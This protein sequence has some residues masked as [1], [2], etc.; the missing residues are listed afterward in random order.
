MEWKSK[1][2]LWPYAAIAIA[3]VGLL[4]VLFISTR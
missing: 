3:A 4:Y 2:Q 1:L